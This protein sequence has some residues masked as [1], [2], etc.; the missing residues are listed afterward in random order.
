MNHRDVDHRFTRC[1][2]PF[3]VLAVA[4]VSPQ[5]ALGQPDAAIPAEEASGPTSGDDWE[6][7][8]GHAPANLRLSRRFG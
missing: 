3:E 5:P 7:R 4:S 2:V 1:G 8:V 6:F